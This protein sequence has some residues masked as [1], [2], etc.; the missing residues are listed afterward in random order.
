MASAHAPLIGIAGWK[1]SGKTTLIERLIPALETHG[2]KVATLKHSHHALRPPDGAT[3]GERHA[4]AG[5]VSVAVIGADAWELG[6]KRQ[7]SAPPSLE[8]A[9]ATLGPADIILVEGFKTAAIPK[10]EVRGERP[11]RP[12]APDDVNIFAIATDAPDATGTLPVFARDDAAALAAFI[13]ELAPH[14]REPSRLKAI[15][16]ERAAR[17]FQRRRK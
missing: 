9:A 16:A 13:A 7:A 4:R 1:G 11:E 8:A 12:L 10:I 14:L 17:T 2:L 15:A 6:G 3:D 5:A